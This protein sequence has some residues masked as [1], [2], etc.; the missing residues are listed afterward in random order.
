L[1][2]LE[3][4]QVIGLML[5]DLVGDGDLT[6]HGIDGHERSLGCL[7]SARWSR[8]SGMAVISLVFSGTLSCPDAAIV[9]RIRPE[10]R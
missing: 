8:S 10:Q 2:A 7:V 6:T 4:E 5:D 3:R 1:V 9:Q